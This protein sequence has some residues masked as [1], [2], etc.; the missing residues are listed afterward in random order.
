MR[1]RPRDGVANPEPHDGRRRGAEELD[2]PEL[3]GEPDEIST[4]KCKL[5]AEKAGG[6]ALESAF[7]PGSQKRP[8]AMKTMVRAFADCCASCARSAMKGCSP[9]SCPARVTT[10][11]SESWVR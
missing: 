3:Q 11:L 7:S 2:L 4:Q 8:P 9:R 5:A 6:A 10:P 1:L